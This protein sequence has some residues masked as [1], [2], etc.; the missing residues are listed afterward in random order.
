M[1]EDILRQLQLGNITKRKAEEDIGSLGLLA[2]SEGITINTIVEDYKERNNIR[3]ISDELAKVDDSVINKFYHSGYNGQFSEENKSLID[4]LSLKDGE[5]LTQLK[6]A[7]KR[8]EG[9]EA[10]KIDRVLNMMKLRRAEYSVSQ[11]IDYNIIFEANTNIPWINVPFEVSNYDD[12]PLMKA[13]NPKTGLRQSYD[14][15]KPELTFKQYFLDKKRITNSDYSKLR[16][17]IQNSNYVKTWLES[18][19]KATLGFSYRDLSEKEKIS[20]YIDWRDSG[21]TK[22]GYTRDSKLRSTGALN[23]IIDYAENEIS[24]ERAKRYSTKAAS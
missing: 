1:I 17:Q 7:R 19:R 18:I 16:R 12:I 14:K 13:E 22:V 6:R 24:P 15:E 2:A 21:K 9:E 10:K 4:N 3:N 20:I 23:R 5:K 11:L 8:L